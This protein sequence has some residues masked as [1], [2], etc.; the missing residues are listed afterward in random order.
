[1]QH[2]KYYAIYI[3][4]PIPNTETILIYT[5]MYTIYIQIYKSELH[6]WVIAGETLSSRFLL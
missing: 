2:C 1:M 3:L 6:L 5:H 4:L